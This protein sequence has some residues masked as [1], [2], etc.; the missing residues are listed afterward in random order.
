MGP[1]DSARSHSADEWVG[2]QEI[3]DAI[4]QYIAFVNHLSVLC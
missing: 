1:G 3:L 4:N 2:E